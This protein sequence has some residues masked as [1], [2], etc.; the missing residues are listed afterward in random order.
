[1]A[2][3]L[4]AALWEAGVRLAQIPSYILPPPS[5][6]YASVAADVVSPTMWWN[7]LITAEETWAGFA[8]GALLG[9]VIGLLVAEF[10]LI[11]DAIYPVV[12]AFQAMPKVAVAPLL[13]I[14]FGFGIASKVAIAALL[15]FFPLLVN[16]VLGLHSS[17]PQQEE[18]MHALSARRSQIFSMVR[19]YN[20]LPSIFAGLEL[21]MVFSVIGAI[22]GEFV[23]AR[24]GLGYMI[25]QRNADTDVPGIFAVLLILGAFGAIM[26]YAVRI[27]AWKVVFWRRR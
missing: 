17:D 3:V 19:L 13:I 22:V 7:L 20:A 18:L 25:Q 14:W 9:F 16:T 23:G 1:M 10:P 12:V 5:Q 6:I 15:A 21:A 26:T 4:F 24:A 27:L 8:S 11:D 2:V